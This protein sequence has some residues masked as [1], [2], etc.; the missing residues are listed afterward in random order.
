MCANFRPYLWRRWRRR[1]RTQST[2]TLR[3]TSSPWA[4]QSWARQPC[5][6]AALCKIGTTLRS[7]RGL[8]KIC[9]HLWRH[10]IRRFLW[11]FCVIC[12]CSTSFR[13]PALKTSTPCSCPNR[14]TFR[15]SRSS[16]LRRPNSVTHGRL[17]YKVRG[18]WAKTR[19]NRASYSS[20]Q[21]PT[22]NRATR[23]PQRALRP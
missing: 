1:R 8:L 22:K 2:T 12:S 13:D 9:W 14:T 16:T 20:L 3:A 23:P 4:S 10:G 5:A 6:Q 15:T 7:S 21:T 17:C 18:L 19:S 11:T